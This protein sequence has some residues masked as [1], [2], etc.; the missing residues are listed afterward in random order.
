MRTSRATSD[1]A[2]R[3]VECPA[4]PQWYCLR[5]TV[6]AE[7]LAAANLA[8]QLG[9]ETYCPRIRYR[10][11]TRRGPVWTCEA[12]FPSYLF[13][14]FDLA[15]SLRGVLAT[16]KVHGIV[17][18]GRVYAVVPEAT[19]ADLRTLFPDRAPRELERILRPGD[20]AVIVDGPLSSLQVLVTGV[21]PGC[22]RIR[23]LF[24]L[25]GRDIEL[26][27][28]EQAVCPSESAAVPV[29]ARRRGAMME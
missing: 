4:G 11:P 5:A 16:P 21:L 23:V 3:S 7:H 10:Q 14:K 22:E 26:E 27:V 12:L 19:V 9:I 6:R 8:H 13:A 29:L 25:L 2:A 17:R 1:A 28:S 18:F 15:T 20:P 24:R